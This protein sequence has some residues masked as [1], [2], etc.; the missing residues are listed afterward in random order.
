MP[1]LLNERRVK[2]LN[3][4][5]NVFQICNHKIY[6]VDLKI[7]REPSETA[8]QDFEELS[9]NAENAFDSQNVEGEKIQDDSS[10]GEEGEEEKRVLKKSEIPRVDIINQQRNDSKVTVLI[11]SCLALYLFVSLRSDQPS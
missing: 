7:S 11:P 4:I 5:P 2:S 3:D 1:F 9:K 6:S 10:N 8:T